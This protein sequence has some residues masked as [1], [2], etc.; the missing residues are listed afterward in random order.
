MNIDRDFFRDVH[1]VG[2]LPID[3]VDT[4]ACLS[5][6]QQSIEQ[7]SKI[8]FTTPNLNFVISSLNDREFYDSVV[9]SDLVVA[10]GISI[11]LMAKIN[12]APIQYRVAGSDIFE[13]LQNGHTEKKLKVYFFGGM[14]GVAERAAQNLKNNKFI[15]CVGTYYP[16]FLDVNAM[17]E[18]RIIQHINQTSPEFLVVALGAKK[19]QLWIRRNL[20]Q[21]N[22]NIVSHLGAVINFVAG[23]VKRAPKLIQKLGLEWAWRIKEEPALWKRYY[24]DALALI[25]LLASKLLPLV[26]L[27]FYLRLLCTTCRSEATLLFKEEGDCVRLTFS[28]SFLENVSVEHRALLKNAAGI[29]KDLYIDLTQASY[30]GTSI[31]ALLVLLHGYVLS[32]GNKFQMISVS[33]HCKRQLKY[34]LLDY[35]YKPKFN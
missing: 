32:N 9:E 31:M 7:K 10:D 22:T 27:N 12:G 8:F 21:L 28:G 6:I 2:G 25:K 19:G 3:N 11:L 26:I 29:K 20:S 13:L 23:S 35:L 17:S 34:N 1:C 15:Q 18:A 14:E 33:S 30:L 24:Y 4:T 16:G 5:I